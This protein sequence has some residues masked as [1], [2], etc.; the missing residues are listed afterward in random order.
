M[1]T[2]PS[3]DTGTQIA[4]PFPTP[5]GGLRRAI[6]VLQ[7]PPAATLRPTR[8]AGPPPDL[9]RPW[10]PDTCPAVMRRAVWTWCEAVA[11]WIN[12]EYCWR[13]DTMIPACWPA[14]PHIA[15]ELAALAVQRWIAEQA[16]DP[17]PIEIWHRDTYPGFC[18]RMTQ[19]LGESTC[20]AGRHI[21]WP[22]AARHAA[23]L[24]SRPDRL[25]VIT[26][27]SRETVRAEQRNVVRFR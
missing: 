8:P 20:R 4:A 15:R 3:T 18:Q 21:D 11:E 23:Y 6:D 7:Q 10:N 14:H 13:P 16:T 2:P 22:A 17:Q 25:A 19:R 9:L 5:P 1:T 12:H 24:D 26:D 27:D